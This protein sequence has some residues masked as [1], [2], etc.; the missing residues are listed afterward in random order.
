MLTRSLLFPLVHRRSAILGLLHFSLGALGVHH[1]ALHIEVHLSL[2]H[3][4]CL[5]R[6]KNKK[7]RKKTKNCVKQK[8]L[9]LR[10]KHKNRIQNQ[11]NGD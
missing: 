6:D 8:I 9:K 1:R 5:W 10:H 2:F 7:M 11:K 4:L 3:L